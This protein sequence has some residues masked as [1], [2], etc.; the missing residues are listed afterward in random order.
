[1][2]QRLLWPRPA[3]SSEVEAKS[4]RES[5]LARRMASAQASRSPWRRELRSTLRD[6]S[7]CQSG[8]S[9]GSCPSGRG[10][11]A[12]ARHQAMRECEGF[13]RGVPLSRP[14]SGSTGQRGQKL[15]WLA[16]VAEAWQPE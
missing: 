2:A 10:R 1:M 3:V 11:G 13:S 7:V 16:R 6:S 12:D 5:G 8:A 15:P 9:L 4:S 14:R